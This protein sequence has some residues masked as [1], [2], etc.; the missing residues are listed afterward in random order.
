MKYLLALIGDET[1]FAD[2]TP[3][4]QAESMKAWDDYTRATI[5]AGVHLG[6][7][8]LQPSSAATTV[9]IQESGE[10]IVSDGPFAE[11]KEQLAGYYL[12]D[13]KDLDDALAWAK[14]IPMPGGT[15]EVRPVMD[16]EAAGSDLHSNEARAE[17]RP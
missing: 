11:T 12:L 9:Q 10:P 4:Q 17:A 7:E 14:R 2:R 3:E 6:G 15:V 8:G 16:Y 13:C 5:E 1:R